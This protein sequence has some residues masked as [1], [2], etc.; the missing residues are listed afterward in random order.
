MDYELA[1]KI[2]E[3]WSVEMTREQLK[4]ELRNLLILLPSAEL[5]DIN[6]TL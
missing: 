5:K 1:N 2:A 4:K 3:T 6:K